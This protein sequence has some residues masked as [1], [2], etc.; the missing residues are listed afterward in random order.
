[1]EDHD[2]DTLRRELASTHGLSF[3][4][5]NRVYKRGAALP[6]EDKVQI[7][8]A[9][10]AAF[11]EAGSTRPNIAHLAKKCCVSRS[12]ITKIEE[13]LVQLGRIRDPKEIRQNR[14]AP[15]GPGALSLDE[16]DVFV[17]LMLYNK[18]PS[19][20]NKQYV[21]E[22]YKHTGTLVHETTIGRFFNHGFEIKGSKCTANNIPYDKF[23]P[24][25]LERAIEYL[26]VLSMFDRTRIKY[27]DEKHLKGSELY[28]R[29]TRRNVLT[30]QVPPI[31]TH[32]DFRNTYSIVGFCG[33][34]SRATPMRYSIAEGINDAE[35]FA[36]QVELAISSG[37][38]SPGDV[39]VLDRAAI[40]TGGENTVL[41]DWL[42]DNFRIFLL[43]LPARTPEWNP[44]ELV[45]NILVQRLAV[46]S[47][48]IANELGKHSLVQVSQIILDKITHVEVEG[49]YRKCGV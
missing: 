36:L 9:Y 41:E 48:E 30:G 43:L 1:M 32:P 38:L 15:I 16:F 5:H 7:G 4:Q 20:S 44:I 18:D 8:I 26:M 10:L 12:M 39:L 45:W 46:F 33:I 3:N 35:N 42:W 2:I 19:R 21:V 37:W 14:D 27:G 31:M 17:I 11:A 22:L 28:C 24:E 13:E 40:H 47:L 29:K 34:D 6:L 25:N 23:R 49:C